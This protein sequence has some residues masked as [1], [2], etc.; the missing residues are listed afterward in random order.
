[1]KKFLRLRFAHYLIALLSLSSTQGMALELDWSGQFWSEFNYLRG[2]TTD[3]VNDP[4]RAT[5]GGYYVPNQGSADATFQSLFL[6]LRPKAIVNDNI[7]IKS[8]FWAGDPVFGLFGSAVPSTLDQRMY[9]SNQSKGS[10]ISAQRF[11]GE[12][13]SDIGTFQVGR[14]PLHWGLGLVWNSGD[15]VWDRYMSSGDGVRWIAKFGSFL[16]SPS[17][18]VESTGGSVA[19]MGGVTDLSVIVK[20]ENAE[21]EVELGVNLL[22]RI[23]SSPSDSNAGLNW[24]ANYSQPATNSAIG[25][26]YVTYDFFARKR[27][28]QVSVGLEVPLT[29]GSLN[30][31]SYQGLGVASEIDWK[32]NETWDLLLK[33]GYAS[34]QSSSS[35]A[36]GNSQQAFYFNPN[37]HIGMI[38][39]N[40]QLANLGG[41]QTA[42]NPGNSNLLQSPYDNPIVNAAYASLSTQIKAWDKWTLKP[43]LIYA[44]A[45]SGASSGSGYFYNYWT[46]SWRQNN[47]GK[48]QGSS[49]GF[50]A[51]LGL[52]FQWDEYFSF[53]L[54]TGLFVPGSF[55]AFSNTATDNPLSPIFAAAMRIG[56]TF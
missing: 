5:A 34:G 42:N 32:P 27:F 44:G 14:V 15:N 52:T 18:I 53:A 35:S 13:I 26:N 8:E 45:L 46:R 29:S 12:F 56:V 11:W 40:Y 48:T 17:L 43:A 33:A 24:S 37:Y 28:Q 38:M 25:M 10:V 2:Y 23:G 4:T 6:R 1:M 19:Q 16:F 36:T 31:V 39:F 7:S 20:Y 50:E 51:D 49:L 54:D 55:Y 41:A 22:K 47:S 30:N 3:V 21:D 9:Y